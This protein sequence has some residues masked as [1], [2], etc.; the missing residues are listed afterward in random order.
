MNNTTKNKKNQEKNTNTGLN[1]EKISSKKFQMP[2]FFD[3]MRGKMSSNMKRAISTCGDMVSFLSSKG[4]KFRL[5]SGEFCNNRFCPICS[6][7]K[8]KKD[9]YLLL[10][11]FSI[12]Q[13][14]NK[15][16]LI[17]LTLTAPNVVKEQLSEEIKDF[18]KAFERMGKTKKFKA[19]NLGY[20]RKLEVTY[21]A[22]RNDYHPHFHVVIAVNKSYFTS[23]DYIKS[24]EWLEMWRDAKRD[25]SITQ[26]D[27]RKAKL[28]DMQGVYEMATYSAKAS[29]Y[30]YSDEVFDGFY[31]AL[32]GKQLITFNG[33]FKE[34]LKEMKADKY[35]DLLES[36]NEI[37]DKRLWYKWTDSN[38]TL[39]R[40]DNIDETEL[41][42]IN[43]NEIEID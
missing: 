36:E 20:I 4:E 29:D 18:N 10:A 28:D 30:L 38:Y 43:V 14:V 37:Y 33:L 26:V 17:F 11:L 12:V 27:I 24:S 39:F 34:T 23:R 22:E 41:Q 8:A 3:K 32:K 31:N 19:M 13:K 21:N 1:L 6:W 15:K 2:N 7:R 25:K 16:E 35:K 42:K 40:E 9:G 5:H